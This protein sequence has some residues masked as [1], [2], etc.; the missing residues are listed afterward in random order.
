MATCGKC[1]ATG[2][3]VAHVRACFSVSAHV[4]VPTTPKRADYSSTA[5]PGEFVPDSDYALV[6]TDGTYIFY[7]VRRGKKG[8][9]AGFV[10]VDQLV[11]SQGDWAKY[12]V[13]GQNKDQVLRSLASDPH[14][15][16]LAFSREHGV[17]ACCGSPLSDADSIARGFGPVCAQRFA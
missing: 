15:H 16:A 6:K 1:Q 13:K 7:R 3:D 12:P 2:V 10:F 17:C 9:W 4:P 11:G 5:N 14:G 8:K